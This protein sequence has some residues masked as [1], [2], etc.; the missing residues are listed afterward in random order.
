M[1]AA[2]EDWENDW[3]DSQSGEEI[4]SKFRSPDKLA[5]ESQTNLRLPTQKAPE[6]K[7][8]KEIAAR[9]FREFRPEDPKPASSSFSGRLA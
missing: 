5:P 6:S 9:D 1:S 3:L 8:A 2:E 4:D 7:G